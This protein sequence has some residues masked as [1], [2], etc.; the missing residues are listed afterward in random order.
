M[1]TISF[2]LIDRAWAGCGTA[3]CPVDFSGHGSGDKL[4][5]PSSSRFNLQLAF[6]S[7]DQNRPRNGTDEVGFGEV[8]RPDHDEIETKNRNVRFLLNYDL[9]PR[10]S[11]SAEVPLLSRSHAHLARAA[12]RHEG[13]EDDHESSEKMLAEDDPAHEEGEDGDVLENWDFTE[14][15]DVQVWSRYRPWSSRQLEEVGLSIG[16]GLSLPTGS[17]RVRNEEGVLAEPSLQPSSGA[18]SLLFEVSSQYLAK[19]PGLSAKRMAR[20]FASS[21]YRLNS[22]GKDDYKFGNEWRFHVGG[23][24]PLRDRVELLG[25]VVG[26][27]AGSDE[28]GKSGELTD[29]TGGTWIFLSPGLQVGL[30]RG[31]SLYGYLQL[32]MYQDVNEV[33]ITSDQNL[34]VGMGYDFSMWR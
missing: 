33:Q 30:A 12:H 34:L 25:Q 27:W 20:F 15:G 2:G 21:L 16:L 8:R 19:L 24:Y 9:S 22:T 1:L 18:F 28:P 10:W 23:R 5:L 6:E 26:R 29:A 3:S 7:I 4:N 17:T 32:P 14:L 31:L 11:F 13:E